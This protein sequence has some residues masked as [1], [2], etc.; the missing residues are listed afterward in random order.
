MPTQSL[1]AFEDMLDQLF[2]T[3]SISS[4]IP[5]HD[6]SNRPLV[7]LLAG[8]AESA[9]FRVEVQAVPD[10]PGKVNLV[11][12]MGE[13]AGGLVMAG[14]TDTVPYDIGAWRHDP[15]RAT[16]T[17]DRVYG[18]GAADMKGFFAFALAAATRIDR[19][20][21][22]A[23]L[24]LVATADEESTMSGARA[25]TTTAVR[26]ERCAIIGEP[27]GLRPVRAHKGIMM[28]ALRVRGHSGHSS[29][30]SLGA[31]AIDGMRRVLDALSAWRDELRAQHRDPQFHVPFPTMNFGHLH[32]GDN[33]NRICPDCLLQLDLR[34]LPG[35]DIE[36]LRAELRHRAATA[37]TDTPFDIEFAALFGGVPAM[38]VAADH[39]LVRT[40]EELS[41]HGAQAVAFAT[42]APHL[43]ELGVTPVV[44]GPG[45]IDQAHQPDEYLAL[46]RVAPMQ[47]ILDGLVGKYCLG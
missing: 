26:G 14:H 18:L 11:A 2:A 21:L 25:L 23:P 47:R 28:E 43:V 16:F 4:M 27:T 10:A 6:M 34:P 35:M 17:D 30:P 32:G 5:A 20:R 39:E 36:A 38:Q 40:A 44:L 8:W 15:F 42:E 13:G 9:G 22:R 45:D 46:E 24:M 7:D 33:P 19:K 37:L 12:V 41:G 3:P 1:P 29:D 31:N